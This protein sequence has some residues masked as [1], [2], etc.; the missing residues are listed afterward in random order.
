MIHCFIVLTTIM[1]DKFLKNPDLVSVLILGIITAAAVAYGLLTWRTLPTIGSYPVAVDTQFPYQMG[2]PDDIISLPNRLTEIS[3]LSHWGN[4][5]LLTVQDEDGKVFIYGLTEKKVVE[6]FDFGKNRDYEGITHIDSTI[7]VL[8]ADG[9]MYKINYQKGTKKYASVK[10]ESSFKHSN[11]TEG[12]CFDP[13]T[14]KMLI[15]P[16]EDQLG[17]TRD[18]PHIK[19]V[20]TMDINTTV[21]NEDPLVSINEF[22]LGEIIYGERKRYEIKPSGVAVHPESGEIYV[23]AS[24]GKLLVVM[25][26]KNTVVHVERLDEK[27]FPQ[28]EGISFNEKGDLFISSEGKGRKAVIVRFNSK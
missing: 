3:G 19:G 11:D 9:D 10:I 20:Y 25:S 18:Q 4:N 7:Y 8:E 5:Q 14:K 13:I 21:V 24:V 16:K 1:N 2:K 15:A 17:P 28:P 26:R 23:L 6:E 22:Q 27:V 12:I